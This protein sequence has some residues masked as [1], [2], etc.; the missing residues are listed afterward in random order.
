MRRFLLSL[1]ALCF[2]ALPAAPGEI[3]LAEQVSSPAELGKL[4][5]VAIGSFSGTGGELAG[6]WQAK[7]GAGLSGTFEDCTTTATNGTSYTSASH[8]VGAAAAS[9]KTLVGVAVVGGGVA[10]QATGVTVG[11][12]T[13]TE[14]F[15][16]GNTG[17]GNSLAWFILDNPTGT[18]ED[19]VLT[20]S[21]T[22]GSFAI[23]TWAILNSDF[24]YPTS[25]ATDIGL[26]ADQVFANLDLRSNAFSAGM[27]L[28]ANPETHTWAG[29]TES[30]DFGPGSES[31]FSAATESTVAAEDNRAISVTPSGSVTQIMT[32]TFSNDHAAKVVYLAGCARTITGSTT[33]TFTDA[34]AGVPD[35]SRTSILAIASEDAATNFNFTSASVGGTAMTEAVETGT[36]GLIEASLYAVANATGDEET[37]SIVMSEATS[38]MV[39]CM[40]AAYGLG[41]ATA[42]AATANATAAGASISGNV[43]TD[44][45]G[46][47]IALC[48]TDATDTQSLAGFDT[49]IGPDIAN[50]TTGNFNSGTEDDVAAATPRT[51]SCDAALGTTDAAIAAGS[52]D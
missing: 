50:G 6:F 22:S 34:G 17:A 33:Y 14:I 7:L 51:V 23:C 15:D 42:N 36:V 9:R 18:A 47:V 48:L 41:S 21:A 28:S 44:A 43:N 40:Y 1:L 4:D 8:D 10:I 13:A 19:I 37:L 2:L 20:A 26:A 49:H 24:S 39:T 38:T 30:D 31:S 46:V 27:A 16:G 32:I 45:G 12:D 35:A 25:V 52:W 11:G 3:S 29:L 5:R